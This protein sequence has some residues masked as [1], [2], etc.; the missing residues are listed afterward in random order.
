M[1]DNYHSVKSRTLRPV[2]YTHL[3]VYKRQPKDTV[4]PV[5]T[6]RQRTEWS[7]NDTEDETLPPILFALWHQL[8][9]I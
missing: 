9:N 1:I 7:C 5:S 6:T 2:S 4:Q 8:K 3:D